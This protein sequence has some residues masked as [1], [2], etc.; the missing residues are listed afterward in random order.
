[1]KNWN[2]LG[3]IVWFLWV[4]FFFGYEFFTGIEQKRDIPMLTQAVVRYV[5]WWITLPVIA[6][7]FLHFVTRYFNPAYLQWL[8]AGNAG[9]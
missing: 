5:P 1:M 8:K 7:M 3:V 4:A 9:G 6:W 2:T